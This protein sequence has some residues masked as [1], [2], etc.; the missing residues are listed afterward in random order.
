VAKAAA[1]IKHPDRHE[2]GFT[3]IEVII[4]LAL[5]ALI[6]MAGLAMVDSIVRVEERTAGRLDR[7][8]QIQRTM[9]VLSR[10]L[11]QMAAGSLEQG[12]SGIAFRR[13][14]A[15]VYEPPRQI[16]YALQGD[17]L[18]RAAGANQLLLDGVAGVTWSFF[19]PN[20]GWQSGLPPRDIPNP[21]Q[22]SAVAVEIS[23]DGTGSPSGT[24]RRVIE[25]PT[26]PAREPA[27]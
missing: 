12:G 26:L 25:L 20:R 10:D 9:F 17:S 5:F 19:F 14:A 23:L 27:Q 3:L 4:S 8:G 16:G 15:S 18:F 2:A 7:L 21:E 6:S 13:Q 22:P 1:M 11:E 24:L